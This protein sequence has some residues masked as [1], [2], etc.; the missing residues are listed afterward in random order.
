[1]S[2]MLEL[3]IEVMIWAFGVG[4]GWKLGS[5]IA[6]TSAS[7]RS[8]EKPICNHRHRTTIGGIHDT[9]TV[10]GTSAT[11]S[12]MFW[13]CDDCDARGVVYGDTVLSV[14]ADTGNAMMNRMMARWIHEGIPPDEMESTEK[15]IEAYIQ[16]YLRLKV[17]GMRPWEGITSKLE[18]ETGG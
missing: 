13:V 3:S 14:A 5:D 11:V 17:T 4:T 10:K 15:A 7:A 1:M 9:F 16:N 6:S 2:A 12:V 8:E 18:T